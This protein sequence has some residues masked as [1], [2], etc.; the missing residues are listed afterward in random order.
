MANICYK[1]KSFVIITIISLPYKIQT[2]SINDY[3]NWGKNA[4]NIGDYYGAAY[5]YKK[6]L[7]CDSSRLDILWEVAEANRMFNNYKEAENEYNLIL[8]LDKE[9]KYP[10]A[11]FWLAVMNKNNGKYEEALNNFKIFLSNDNI[12]NNELFNYNIQKAKYEIDNYPKIIQIAY[13][14]LPVVVEKLENYINTQFSDFGAVQLKDSVLFFS[15]LRN[16]DSIPEESLFSTIYL[17]KIYVANASPTGWKKAKV[18]K[19]KINSK[20]YHDANITFS[21]DHTCIFFSRCKSNGYIPTNCEIYQSKLVNGVFQKP[22]KLNN[23]INLPGYSTT[24]PFFAGC[25]CSNNVEGVLYFSSDRPGGYGK[26]DIWYSIYKNGKFNDPVNLGSIINTPGDEITPFYHSKTT[27]LYFSS[28]WLPGIGGFDIFKS[29]GA[30]NEWTYPENLGIPINSKANDLYFTV[31]EVDDDGYFTSNREGSF[32]IKGETCCNDIFSYSWP[33][34]KVIPSQHQQITITKDTIIQIRETIKSL[35]PITLYFHNDEP[36]PGSWATESSKNYQQTLIEYIQM[37]DI[38]K[39]EYAKG[40]TGEARIRA[41]N[42]IEDFFNNYVSKGFTNLQKF[43]SLLLYDLQ[44]GN[45]INIKI[46][47]FCSPLNTTKYNL[48]LAKRRISSFKKYIQEY[49]GGVFIK[50]LEG[51]SDNGGKLTIY[52]DPIGKA[53]A[54]P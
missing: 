23:K 3:I 49:A 11:R 24:Q 1:I 2:Q 17:T 34:E 43:T 9:N 19:S 15:S 40:L 14:T 21:S 29:K 30:L 31:N 51:T 12:K 32:Y 13:D 5:Y 35:L 28:D 22:E 41:E 38:Y 25:N 53:Q 18:W 44:E 54:N 4:F 16:I 33:K 37:K 47:G 26:Y 46:K 8:S 27:T 39:Q 52:E 50:Y 20:E 45:D 10:Q 36:D 6:A 48:N 7:S 42:D